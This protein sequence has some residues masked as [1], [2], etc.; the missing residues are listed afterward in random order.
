MTNYQPSKT[1][2]S[3][4]LDAKKWLGG[5]GIDSAIIDAELIL[6]HVLELNRALLLAHS[7][8]TIDSEK[9]AQVDKLL[10]RRINQEPMAYI[11]GSKEFF[12]LNFLCD[13]RALI[14]RSESEVMVE[15]ALT[16]LRHAATPQ[17][18]AEIGVGTGAIILSVAKNAPEH[19]YIGTDISSDALELA[20]ENAALVC[21]SERPDLSGV[22]ESS[23][24]S[25]YPMS[26]FVRLV[27]TLKSDDLIA[28]TRREDDS[29]FNI[30]FLQGNLADPL[31]NTHPNSIN[32]L[33]A[34][35]PYIPTWKIE[36]LDQT[37][38]FFEP[39]LALDGGPDGLD[40]YRQLTLQLP[41]ILAPAAIMLFEHDPEQTLPLT[42]TIKKTF[43]NALVATIKDHLGDNRVTLCQTPQ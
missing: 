19:K 32:L 11:L 8:D 6:S 10:S 4:L 9:L 17:T 16:I 22:E 12:G 35:L 2:S 36:N 23:P 13:K 1:I 15:T 28:Q 42:E 30:E 31:L 21:H 41:S 37:I 3:W 29:T 33:L 39:N 40:P 7:E 43:P 25:G 5:L 34:N 27:S 14:P 26:D 38:K 24:I 18:V 20:K